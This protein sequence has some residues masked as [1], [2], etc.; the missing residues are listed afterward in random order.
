M[1]NENK[2]TINVHMTYGTKAQLD[3]LKLFKDES[4][5]SVVQRLLYLEEKYNQNVDV[6]YEYEICI[7]D[8]S[9]LFK[10]HWLTDSYIIY[11]YSRIH[12]EYTNSVEAWGSM[13][14]DM[15]GLFADRLLSL[16]ARDDCRKLLIDLKGTLSLDGYSIRKL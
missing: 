15:N 9:R 16:F 5:D 3:R 1:N 7:A 13:D 10:V 2:T 6:E 8:E 12:H 11:Y 14:N 4:Y